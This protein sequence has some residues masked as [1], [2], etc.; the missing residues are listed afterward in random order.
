MTSPA[1]VLQPD[2]LFEGVS[3][4]YRT[5]GRET[6]AVRDVDLSVRAGEFVSLLGPSGCGK[7]SLLNMAAGLVRSTFGTVTHQGKV[8][9]GANTAVGYM[10]QQDSVLPWRTARKNVELP[11]ELRGMEKSRR[12]ELTQASLQLVGLHGSADV[13][14][15]ALSGG[16]KKRVSLAQTLVYEPRTLLLDEPFAALDAMLRISL[17]EELSRIIE[18][19][20]VTALLVTHD[21]DEAIALSDRVVIMTNGPGRIKEIVPIELPRPRQVAEVRFS[22]EYSMIRE[23]I[24]SVLEDEVRR[25]AERER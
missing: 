18:E 4:T 20:G 2:L 12:R 10:T 7:T 17:H 22:N 14:P 8:V 6:P 16:M 21:M 3:L 9:G 15:S 25:H 5:K 19:T 11:L 13:Y 24:W 1:G 23:R